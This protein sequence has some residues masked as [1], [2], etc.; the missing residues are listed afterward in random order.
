MHHTTT[1]PFWRRH[2]QHVEGAGIM[3]V[4]NHAGFGQTPTQQQ[5]FG[6]QT[7]QTM[8][9]RGI[10]YQ[11]VHDSEGAGTS[12]SNVYMCSIVAMPQFQP[13][14]EKSALELRWEDYQV[15]DFRAS[16]M[17]CDCTLGQV[18]FPHVFLG[19]AVKICPCFTVGWEADAETGCEF[20][21]TPGT[22][23]TK[24]TDRPVRHC[25]GGNSMLTNWPLDYN[26][27]SGAQRWKTYLQRGGEEDAGF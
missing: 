14:N 6:M 15:L 1:K 8:G 3:T 10:Q 20:C 21:H 2:F 22:T 23:N 9:T 27:G 18:L 26:A 11:K 19:G 25:A 16:I 7:P 24:S 12:K 4:V 13:P 17:V 5:G